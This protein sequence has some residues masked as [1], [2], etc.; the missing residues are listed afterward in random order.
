M[1]MIRSTTITDVPGFEKIVIEPSDFN[2]NG[3]HIVLDDGDGTRPFNI[4][5]ATQLR[6]ALGAAIEEAETLNI[7]LDAG[8][9]AAP[10]PVRLFVVGQELDSTEDLPVG[11]VI[12]DR[13]GT[14]WTRHRQ[15]WTWTGNASGRSLSFVV[16]RY[17]PVRIMSLPG[18]E[19]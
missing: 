17:G 13:D 5:E 3:V 19:S 9:A 2:E 14:H 10:K 7:V 15:G 18:G 12:V 11:T 16:G 8:R 1:K 6:D 4:I